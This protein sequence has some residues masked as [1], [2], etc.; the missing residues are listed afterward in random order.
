[1]LGTTIVEWQRV[2]E[3]MVID[4]CMYTDAPSMLL[5]LHRVKR[6]VN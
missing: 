2:E 3:Q 6:C 1:M 4:D 5:V